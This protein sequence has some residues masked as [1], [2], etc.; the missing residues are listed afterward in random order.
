M[1][2]LVRVA[3]GVWREAGQ[4]G[5][6][7][8]RASALLAACP[9]GSVIAGTAAAELHGLWLPRPHQGRIDVVVRPDIVRGAERMH[10]ARPEIRSRRIVLADDEVTQVDGLPVLTLAR[11]WLDLAGRLS[12]PDL[13]ALGDSAL[14][15]GS[16]ITEFAVLVARARHRP[17]VVGAR[18]AL[19]LVD[20]RSRSRPESHLRYWVVMSGFPRP[21]PNTAIYSDDHEW[22]CEPDL[23][24]DDVKLALEYNGADHADVGRQ[25]RDISRTIDVQERGGWRIET[26]GPR[27][28]FVLPDTI[29]RRVRSVRRELGA[30]PF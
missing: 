12:A 30:R 9:A 18:R 27:E 20:P 28:V 21:I 15:A 24:F 10:T 4:V 7:R 25:R 23:H 3:R 19:P 6:L 14:R 5:D 1:T 26:F 11:T 22:L 17:G 13:V 16:S 8:G 29:A 2:E